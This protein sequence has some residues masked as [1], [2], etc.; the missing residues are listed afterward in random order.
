MN[1]TAPS[2]TTGLYSVTSSVEFEPLE[3]GSPLQIV[4]RFDIDWNISS[5]NAVVFELPG[6][7]GGTN[8]NLTLTTT[9]GDFTGAWDGLQE[10]TLTA[11]AQIP[12]SK[13]IVVNISK[14]NE[15]YLPQA[16]FVK[17]YKNFTIS[18]NPSVTF[19]RQPLTHSPCVG[20]CSVNIT[21]ESGMAGRPTAMRIN[22]ETSF[23]THPG[24][25]IAINL[26]GFGRIHKVSKGSSVTLNGPSTVQ[27]YSA[28]WVTNQTVP[29]IVI[30]AVHKPRG[31]GRHRSIYISRDE[32]LV[33]PK[34]GVSEASSKFKIEFNSS[35]FGRTTAVA[36]VSGVGQITHASLQVNPKVQGADLALIDPIRSAFTNGREIQNTFNDAK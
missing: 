28:V 15:L 34:T 24:D 31:E 33:L 13:E 32:L 9:R 25:T 2:P 35:E 23:E 36:S 26:P 17:N 16:G 19:Q 10:L 3:L 30:T 27:N 18:L 14:M 11:N 21:F 22:Y 7:K 12:S 5:T 20:V 29:E 1:D 8:N 6:L 4:L